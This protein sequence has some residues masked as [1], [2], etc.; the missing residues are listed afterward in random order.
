MGLYRVGPVRTGAGSLY[1]IAGRM[2][3]P[4]AGGAR[5]LGAYRRRRAASSPHGGGGREA[6]NQRGR[7][8]PLQNLL[9]WKRRMLTQA[10]VEFYHRYGYVR[11]GTLLEADEVVTLR[12]RLDAVLAGASDTGDRVEYVE[13]IEHADPAQG[14]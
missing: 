10:D 9:I 8:R 4:D 6:Y 2:P 3:G 11:G 1:L 12:E 13:T 5:L 14:E 7:S